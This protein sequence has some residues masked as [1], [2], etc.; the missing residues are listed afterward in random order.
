[1]E[2]RNSVQ[3][4]AAVVPAPAGGARASRGAVKTT[5]PGQP[6][7]AGAITDALR[8]FSR[9]D[10]APA[11][12]LK[13]AGEG[14]RPSQPYSTSLTPNGQ[15]AF[16]EET[17]APLRG[18]PWPV[19][20]WREACQVPPYNGR[21]QGFATLARYLALRLLGS[22][23]KGSIKHPACHATKDFFRSHKGLTV[24]ELRGQLPGTRLTRIRHAAEISTA[25]TGKVR[26]RRRWQTIGS[27]L[28]VTAEA[29]F[30]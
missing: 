23:H 10:S 6:L 12:C 18:P 22:L 20:A 24:W 13:S 28:P 8:R 29:A 27:S 9:I 17:E 11:S 25:D 26:G 4:P 3:P 1:M 15:W 2:P 21:S 14:T 30:P 7:S 5:R 16:V 19:W